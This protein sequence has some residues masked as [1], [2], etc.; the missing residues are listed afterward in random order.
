MTRDTIA[1]LDKVVGGPARLAGYSNGASIALEVALQRPDLVERLVLV[2]GVFA[3]E[4]MLVKPEPG[5]P[6]PEE[7]AKLYA[8]VSPTGPSTSRWWWPRSPRWSARSPPT[9]S[10]TSRAWA[11]GRW[12]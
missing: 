2:S 10:P 7:M 8:E 4:G 1:F 12:S 3:A 6:V 9:T 5:A 11:A